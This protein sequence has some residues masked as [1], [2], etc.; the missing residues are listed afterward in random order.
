[1]TFGVGWLVFRWRARHL[2]VLRELL[3]ETRRKLYAAQLKR[4]A[5]SLAAH[6][7]PRSSVPT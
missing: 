1:M 4:P 6:P 3:F 5:E 2:T 7:P